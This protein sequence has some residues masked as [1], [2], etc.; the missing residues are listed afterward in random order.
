MLECPGAPL[1]HRH[2]GVTPGCSCG[3]GGGIGEETFSFSGSLFL[4]WSFNILG[5]LQKS[6]LADS[7]G[8]GVKQTWV[9]VPAYNEKLC[10]LQSFITS[11][12]QLPYL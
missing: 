7:V 3:G 10:T 8:S 12:P 4:S 1:L 9:L 11:E 6:M 2:P 5:A